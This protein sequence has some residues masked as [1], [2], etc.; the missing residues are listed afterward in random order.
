MNMSSSRLYLRLQSC[1]FYS[2]GLRA[3]YH[4]T[5]D[6][7][8]LM[9]PPKLRPLYNH[10]AGKESTL[11]PLAVGPK[12]V[13]FWAPVFKWGLV[14]AGFSDMTRP[15]EKLSVSQSCVITAT[16]IIWS[17][18]CLVIIPKNW[19]LFAVNFF[20]GMCGSIQLIRIW[21]YNQQLKQ[22]GVEVP[23]S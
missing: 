18:Y 9:L 10:P 8:E 23:Q 20:L 3:T 12:T 2:G 16:G 6:R 17:R 21:R 13:F 1:R 22:K 19:A 14:V 5:L 4:R 15:P 11:L 7:I